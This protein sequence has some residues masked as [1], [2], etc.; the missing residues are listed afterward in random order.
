MD[1]FLKFVSEIMEVDVS[2]IS[3]KTEY[4]NFDIWDSLMMMNLVLELEAEYNISIPMESIN[5]IKTL[6]DLYDLVK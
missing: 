2:E 5:E 1:K 4:K 3:L 6:Q